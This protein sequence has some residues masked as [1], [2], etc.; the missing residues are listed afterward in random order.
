MLMHPVPDHVPAE[1]VKPFNWHGVPD[2]D[3][4]DPWGSRLA[5]LKDCPRVF[6]NPLI[7]TTMMPFGSWVVT[8]T[9]DIQYVLEKEDLFSNTGLQ[10]DAIGPVGPYSSLEIIPLELSGAQHRKFRIMVHNLFKPAM[11]KDWTESIREMAVKLIDEFIDEGETDFVSSFSRPYPV[12]TFLAMMGMPLHQID[13]FLSWEYD[14]LHTPDPEVRAAASQK[15]VEYFIQLIDERRVRPTN[16]VFSKI[17]HAEVSG[18]ILE[19]KQILGVAFNLFTGGLDTVTA[20]SEWIFKHLAENQALQDELRTDLSRVPKVLEELLRLYPVIMTGRTATQDMDFAGVSIK[21]GDRISV[22]LILAN[23]DESEIENPRNTDY[24]RNNNRHLTFG[25]GAHVCVGNHL[26]RL[27]L[28]IAIEEWVTRLPGFRVK[29]GVEL[30]GHPGVV[31]LNE[32]P[33]VWGQR[34]TG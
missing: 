20:T 3:P 12:L 26:A 14:F 2:F 29:P 31:G 22:P 19:N 16:D 18:K 23:Y 8:R 15:I 34:V 1:I 17:V 7:M 13:T 11:V 33:L 6:W 10:S 27:E 4:R 9:K 24:D 21:Q 25:A 30:E 28:R 32:L 5:V